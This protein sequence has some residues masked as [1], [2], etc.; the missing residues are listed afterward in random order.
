MHRPLEEALGG[1]VSV[2]L[3]GGMIS[4]IV[5]DGDDV[6]GSELVE[7]KICIPG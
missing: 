3:L 1:A 2:E 6:S 4:Q 7:R 5:D